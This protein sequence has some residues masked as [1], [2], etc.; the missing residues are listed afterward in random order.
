M[1]SGEHRR[2][3]PFGGKPFTSDDPRINRSG[4][5]K[6]VES[7]IKDLIGEHGEKALAIIWDIAQGKPLEIPGVVLPAGILTFDRV[8]SLELQAR[9]TQW[10]HERAFG[11]AAAA[12]EI[13]SN[14]QPRRAYD[15]SR[16][17]NEELLYLERV[18]Q[19]A[20]ALPE[21]EP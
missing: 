11:K 13:T 7:A 1:N 16:L 19:T 3:P 2:G 18:Q 12:I 4:R 14:G 17:S 9:C 10:L 15:L 6:G 21:G 8:P 5:P 20:L